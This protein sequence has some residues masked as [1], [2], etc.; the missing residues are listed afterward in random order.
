MHDGRWTQDGPKAVWKSEGQGNVRRQ[1]VVTVQSRQYLNLPEEVQEHLFRGDTFSEMLPV[2][3]DSIR[4]RSPR[5]L[6]IAYIEDTLLELANEKPDRIR[7]APA[8]FDPA[9]RT[10]VSRARTAPVAVPVDTA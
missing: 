9:D 3:P 5:N 1:Q 7:L 2:G 6:R 10:T 4:G 8:A